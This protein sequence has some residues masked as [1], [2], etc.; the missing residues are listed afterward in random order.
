MINLIFLCILCDLKGGSTK[1][2]NNEGKVQRH[3]WCST[4]KFL[5]LETKSSSFVMF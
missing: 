1:H 5:T 3:N 2:I 4:V